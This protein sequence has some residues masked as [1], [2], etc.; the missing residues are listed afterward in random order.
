MRNKSLKSVS[1]RL[2]V[3]F[4]LL[5]GSISASAQY[6]L[7]V[8]EK[9]GV[10]RQYVIT[11]LDSISITDVQKQQNTLADLSR[12]TLNKSAV[13]METGDSTVII[14]KG[15]SSNGME[16]TLN[17][18]LWRSSNP[19]VATVDEN[20]KVKTFKSGSSAIT[21]S[22]GLVSA[23]CSLTVV[24]HTYTIAE[25]VKIA[26]DKKELNITTGESGSL[27]VKGYASNGVEIPLT[28]VVWESTNSL[29]ASVD[30]NGKV[31]AIAKGNATITASL[32][33]ISESCV[34]TVNDK[35][36]TPDVTIDSLAGSGIYLGITGFNQQVYSY[37]F[38]VLNDSSKHNFD[39]FID[40]LTLK[41]GTLLYYSVDQAISALK[42]ASFPEDLC[43]VAIVTFTDGLD[44]GSLMYNDNYL[45]DEEYLSALHEIISNTTI[46]GVSLSS[47]AIGVRGSDVTDIN[48][49]QQNL[50]HLATTPSNAYE[51]TDISEVNS[52]FQ[53]IADEL[54]KTTFSQTLSL[55]MPGT[56]HGTIVRFTFDNIVSADKSEL[57]IEGTF[58]LKE[59]KLDNIVYHGLT[60]SSGL[61]VQGEVIN[62]IM[63]RF[64]FEDVITD[65]NEVIQPNAINQWI[66]INSTSSWQINSE[67]ER[68]EDVELITNQK[69]AVIML[70]VDCSSSLGADFDYL[71]TAAKSFVST[72]CL[73]TPKIDNPNITYGYSTTP[74]DMALVVKKDGVFY[75]LS[76][77]DYN[78]AGGVPKGYTGKGVVVMNKD[79]NFWVALHDYYN[80]DQTQAWKNNN[81]VLG[82]APDLEIARLI[83]SRWADINHA[84]ELY[85]GNPL[86]GSYWSKT[87]Y[88]NFDTNRTTYYS[89][90]SSGIQTSVGVGTDSSS[91]RC[92]LR[93]AYKIGEDRM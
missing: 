79:K 43:N 81:A 35:F 7:N 20:G 12:I 82:N 56:S 89:F 13:N 23:T 2:S 53:S 18:V 32:N 19:S 75:Y 57:Y 87:I 69:T 17:N 22:F 9:G 66:Y 65:N 40:D 29:V 92:K 74:F 44:Q 60:S 80:D 6:Y 72:L 61:S 88:Y 1:A 77:Y 25:V 24:D 83:V 47:Y 36:E 14:A 64:K 46:Q 49:F 39:T 63:V 3:I 70:V 4:L 11:N 67:F 93:G 76:P 21:A 78:R 62:G 34:V 10:N 51:V 73:A 8:Y 86:T 59:K 27:S 50:Q 58:N 37:P 41:N 30:E 45:T 91:A 48:K 85:N 54:S 33:N 55:A 28:G 15:Y 42:H 16:I 71:K 5:L 26:L 31:T 84:L 90:G 38:S 52:K 68:E